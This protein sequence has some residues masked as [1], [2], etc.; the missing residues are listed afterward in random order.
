M[1]CHVLPAD[2]APSSPAANTARQRARLV[3]ATNAPA[4]HHTL[5]TLV[6]HHLPANAAKSAQP[7][8]IT[9]VHKLCHDET[10][11]FHEHSRHP[12]RVVDLGSKGS[13]PSAE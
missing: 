7:S 11:D 3:R 1:D 12:T 4:P 2:A 13:V 8:P 9:R 6:L 10:P 5:H